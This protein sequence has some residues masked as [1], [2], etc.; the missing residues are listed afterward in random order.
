MSLGSSVNILH[1]FVVVVVWQT[2][3]WCTF[4]ISA[5]VSEG[6]TITQCVP[7]NTQANLCTSS[8]ADRWVHVISKK[9][10]VGCD[11]TNNLQ[12]NTSQS[13][14]VTCAGRQQTSASC[15]Y[16][17]L[18][19]MTPPDTYSRS[20]T[21][22]T[23]ENECIDE[24]SI[25]NLC[26][27]LSD[28]PTNLLYLASPSLFLV[29]GPSPHTRCRCDIHAEHPVQVEIL[30]ADISTSMFTITCGQQIIVSDGNFT[31]N[32]TNTVM[33]LPDSSTDCVIE[34][35]QRGANRTDGL[36]SHRMW[37]KFTGSSITFRC[38]TNSSA[39]TPSSSSSSSSSTSSSSEKES[40][41][42]MTVSPA[43][44]VVNSSTVTSTSSSVSTFVSLTTSNETTTTNDTNME[45]NWTTPAT[46]GDTTTGAH[47]DQTV[48]YPYIIAGVAGGVV[49]VIIILVIVIVVRKKRGGVKYAT[50]TEDF[51][52][53]R[54]RADANTA[55]LHHHSDLTETLPKTKSFPSESDPQRGEDN[56]RIIMNA[57]Y[58]PLHDELHNNHYE[59]SPKK[60]KP[61][62]HD[63]VNALSKSKQKEPVNK[64]DKNR[65][66]DDD[67]V[68][69]VNDAYESFSSLQQQN[70]PEATRELDGEGSQ[71]E[72]DSLQPKSQPA[73]TKGGDQHPSASTNGNTSSTR[74]WEDDYGDD[75]MEMTVNDLYVSAGEITPIPLSSATSA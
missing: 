43:T 14:T 35:D 38:N 70:I 36:P 40:T 4:H 44:T 47:V 19:H 34:V 26:T 23:L 65:V 39:S 10:Q 72:A 24:S 56:S 58:Q 64:T 12:T 6:T 50:S 41:T 8:C 1:W 74:T 22:V 32:V 15:S 28:T 27:D 18:E 73:M 25:H 7:A 75:E 11:Q 45:G 13:L 46:T 60:N 48:P 53:E 68:M 66:D 2:G 3:P 69:F 63:G 61:Q 49:L 37:T 20:N 42:T 21:T 17:C 59:V 16:G 67:V 54:S 62:P 31:T 29:P 30:F 57:A 51:F 71:R 5:S 33:S 55:G 52:T 9:I